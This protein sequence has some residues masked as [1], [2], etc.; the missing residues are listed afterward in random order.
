MVLS[1]TS[2]VTALNYHDLQGARQRDSFRTLNP[3][4]ATLRWATAD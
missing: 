4:I 2:G 1:C 3:S